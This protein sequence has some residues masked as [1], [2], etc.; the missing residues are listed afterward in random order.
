MSN[1]DFGHFLLERELINQKQYLEIKR[2]QR[3][4]SPSLESIAIKENLID[5]VESSLIAAL[6]K[7]QNASFEKVAMGLHFLDEERISWLREEQK[8]RTIPIQRI[9]AEENIVSQSAIDRF[10]V[11]YDENY[12]GSNYAITLEVEDDKIKERMSLYASKNIEYYKKLLGKDIVY[13]E[14]LDF[15]DLV[16][17]VDS[18]LVVENSLVVYSSEIYLERTKVELGICVDAD[19]CKELAEKIFGSVEGLPDELLKESVGEYLNAVTGLLMS[20][21][22]FEVN[23]TKLFPPKV[24]NLTKMNKEGKDYYFAKMLADGKDIYIF[25]YENESKISISELN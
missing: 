2:I 25:Y 12:Q 4:R 21:S 11:D 14:M 15:S 19:S 10:L 6:K 23:C 17:L 8:K 5:L 20:E 1:K 3:E 13:S 18:S 7:F 9:L 24:R 16:D 22:F